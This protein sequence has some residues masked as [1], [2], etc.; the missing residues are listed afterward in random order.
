MADPLET[1]CPTM[2][3]DLQKLGRPGQSGQAIAE[4]PGISKPGHDRCLQARPRC[5]GD[6]TA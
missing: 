1:N 6:E 4:A 5:E 2:T 3:V